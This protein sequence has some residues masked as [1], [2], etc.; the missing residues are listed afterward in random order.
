MLLDPCDSADDTLKSVVD[1]LDTGDGALDSSFLLVIQ[2]PPERY[3][4]DPLSTQVQHWPELE[5]PS[6]SL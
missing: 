2:E 4:R 1:A 6:A 3:R 5:M